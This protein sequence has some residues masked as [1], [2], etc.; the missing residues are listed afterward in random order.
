MRAGDHIAVDKVSRVAVLTEANDQVA[1]STLGDQKIGVVLVNFKNSKLPSNLDANR[2]RSILLGNSAGG[3]QNTPDWSVDDFWQQNSDGKARV[4]QSGTGSLTVV[5]PYNLPQDLD[6]GSDGTALFLQ[7]TKL[8]DKDLNYKNFAR[9][10]F[11]VPDDVA[12]AQE[13]STVG[14]GSSSYCAGDGA[15]GHSWGWLKAG[16]LSTRAKGVSSA[17]HSLGHQLGLHHAASIDYG[18]EPLGPLD[19]YG[20]RDDRGN[21]F[22]VMGLGGL[23]FYHAPHAIDT[24]GWFEKNKQYVD[25]ATSGA[26]SIEWTG[27]RSGALKALKIQRGPWFLGER[28]DISVEF[29]QN[30]GLYDSTLNPQVWSGGLFHYP[31]YSDTNRSD[32]VDFTPES[33]NGFNDPALAV[34][35]TWNDPYSNLSVKVDSIVNDMLNLTVTYGPERCVPAAPGVE[36]TPHNLRGEVGQPAIYTVTV[37]NRDSPQCPASFTLSSPSTSDGW[38]GTF[39]PS[40]LNIAAGASATSKFTVTPPAEAAGASHSIRV[41][42]NH[43]GTDK[44]NEDYAGCTVPHIIKPGPA[45]EPFPASGAV[46]IDQDVTLNWKRGDRAIWHKVYFGT[47]NPPPF[48]SGS[49]YSDLRPKLLEPGTKYFWRIEEQ[50][51]AGINDSSP[52]WSFTTKD[53][54]P[55][56]PW[57]SAPLERATVR[58]QNPTISWRGA[59]VGG[60][61][62]N[63]DVYFGTCQTRLWWPS[64]LKLNRTCSGGYTTTRE[65]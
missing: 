51:E 44:I 4:K 47:T 56:K 38:A 18:A 33:V 57:L 22:S 6:C 23:G 3:P 17:A 62:I 48:L 46:R 61:P 39:E 59:P 34:G 60:R 7:A 9:L 43:V 13:G 32:V 10:L 40:T 37:T 26:Y 25:V 31:Q 29:R 30:R 53:A 49:S 21:P 64:F 41:A 65:H 5:G 11:I 8:A 55:G 42:G 27:K 54:A 24:L 58:T 50:N 14:C 20:S 36:I 1:C 28:K 16:S 19:V 35:R 63:Y 2:V 45:T 52:V 15:C 12:C